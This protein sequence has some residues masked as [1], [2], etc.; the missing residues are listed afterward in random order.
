[1]TLG[2]LWRF[3]HGEVMLKVRRLEILFFIQFQ[4]LQSVLNICIQDNKYLDAFDIKISLIRAGHVGDKI[5][6]RIYG[7][8]L[9]DKFSLR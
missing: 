2:R 5:M 6:V 3:L 8:L 4:T 7:V 1:M 9:T